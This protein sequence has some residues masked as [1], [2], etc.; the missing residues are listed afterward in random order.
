MISRASA[1]RNAAKQGNAFEDALDELHA[2]YMRRGEAAIVRSPAP[3]RVLGQSGGVF[4]GVFEGTG[5]ADYTGLVAGRGVSFDAKSTTASAWALKK[6]EAHQADWLDAFTAQGGYGFI[7][8]WMQG[9]V[10][11]LPWETLR[12]VWTAHR[13]YR[14]AGQRATAGSASLSPA[15]VAEL[16]HRCQASNWLP[17]VRRLWGAS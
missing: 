13:A 3:F 5:P 2:L 4:R 16:G 1:G 8:L 15:R 17:V 14:V 9:G 10:W 6:L 12:P 7:L 11:V